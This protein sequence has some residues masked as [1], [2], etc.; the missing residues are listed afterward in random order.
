MTKKLQ[1]SPY[2]RSW[3]IIRRRFPEI[4]H[5]NYRNLGWFSAC[6]KIQMH[7]LRNCSKNCFLE[8]LERFFE[9]DKLTQEDL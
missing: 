5:R 6:E 8:N 1:E 3:I 4:A 7:A 2:E 9:I